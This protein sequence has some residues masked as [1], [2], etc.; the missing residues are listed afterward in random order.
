[1][2]YATD[3]GFDGATLNTEDLQLQFAEKEIDLL[4]KDFGLRLKEVIVDKDKVDIRG[5]NQAITKFV[6]E[7]IEQNFAREGRPKKWHPISKQWYRRKVGPTILTNTGEMRRALQKGKA[8]L[9]FVGDNLEFKYVFP[10]SGNQYKYTVPLTGS[11]SGRWTHGPQ[12]YMSHRK[13]RSE[14]TQDIPMGNFKVPP[15]PWDYFEPKAMTS[16]LNEIAQLVIQK[17]VTSKMEYYLLKKG[18][19]RSF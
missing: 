10:F 19:Y 4:F 18:G 13:M 9:Q 11:K 6:K 2:I 5:L 15:R 16:F 7:Q 12:R 14:T 1:M 8:S 17:V 3:Y